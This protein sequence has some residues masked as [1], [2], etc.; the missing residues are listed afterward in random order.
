MLHDAS[1]GTVTAGRGL[2]R[3]G[4]VWEIVGILAAV[5]PCGI[6]AGLY[7][8]A[9]DMRFLVAC[10]AL[11]I[12]AVVLVFI[13]RSPRRVSLARRGAGAEGGATGLT[14]KLA[15]RFRG[16][17]KLAAAGSAV[18]RTFTVQVLKLL[19]FA[20]WMIAWGLTAALYA[21]V[22]QN[23]NM[24]ALMMLVVFGGFSPV[25]IYYGLESGMKKL[26]RRLRDD[27]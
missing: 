18:R 26:G 13:R 14:G 21:R 8:A 19:G 4:G 27:E 5:I 25:M 20:V 12:V 17:A 2:A 23:A 11:A 10:I 9:G 15:D 6:L 7:L 16:S 24:T 22:A 1:T 3:S